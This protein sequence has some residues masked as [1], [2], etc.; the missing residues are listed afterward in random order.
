MSPTRAAHAPI[1]HEHHGTVL[2]E[3]VGVDGIPVVHSACEVLK[4]D[5]GRRT[6]LSEPAIGETD[7]ADLLELSWSGV[8]Q[9]GLR[10]CRGLGERFATGEQD[11][12]GARQGGGAVAEKQTPAGDTQTGLAHE[13]PPDSCA[14]TRVSRCLRPRQPAATGISAD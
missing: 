5:Q 4:A 11:D 6:L 7:I 13:L 8:M 1:V 2:G 3:P 12:R 14:S 10:D 9:I